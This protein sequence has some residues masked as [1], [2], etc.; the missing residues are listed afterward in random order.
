MGTKYSQF[1]LVLCFLSLPMSGMCATQSSTSPVVSITVPPPGRIIA[2]S[3]LVAA[4]TSAGVVGVQFKLDGQN[5][6]AEVTT[7]PFSIIW[8]TTSAANSSHTVTAV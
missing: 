5:L 1:L 6:G 4:A 2:G 8:N 3:V 7:P